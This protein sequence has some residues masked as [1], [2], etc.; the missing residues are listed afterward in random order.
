V[1]YT[2][3][4]LSLTTHTMCCT[5]TAIIQQQQLHTP[6]VKNDINTVQN[7]APNSLGDAGN[8]IKNKVSGDVQTAKRAANDATPSGSELQNAASAAQS[9]V[10]SDVNSV[11]SALNSAVG[12]TVEQGSPA[13]TLLSVEG[14]FFGANSKEQAEVVGAKTVVSHLFF[15]KTFESFPS[16]HCLFSACMHAVPQWSHACTHCSSHRFSVEAMQLTHFISLL[17]ALVKQTE[18]GEE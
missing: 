10:S 8:A 15:K 4:S 2:H 3:T 18:Q 9:K 16:L 5:T 13:S 11:K 7:A 1:L 12:G 6:Q 14:G 17:L